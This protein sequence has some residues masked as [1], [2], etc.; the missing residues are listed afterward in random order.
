MTE[1][2]APKSRATWRDLFGR[3]SRAPVTVLA[4][5][6]LLFATNVYVTTSLLPNAV[7]DIGGK[8]LYS[9]TMTAFLVASVISSMLVGNTLA[10]FG[11]RTSYIGGFAG[12]SAGSVVAALAPSM[13][14]LLVG[15]AVQGLAAGLLAG[16][17]FAVIRVVLP[18]RLWQRSVALLSAMWG[19][20]NVAGPVIGGVFAEL[21]VWRAAF[22]FLALE[23]TVLAV[24]AW[25]TLPSHARTDAARQGVPGFALLLMAGGAAAVSIASTVHGMA[26][27]VLI[28]IGLLLVAGFVA[29]ERSAAVTV[30][31]AMTYRGRSPLRWVYAAIVVLAFVSTVETFLPL[32][33]QR[34]GGM[35][36]LGAGLL[37]ASLSWGWSL[38]SILNGGVTRPAVTRFV[39]AAGPALL[40]IGLLI[41]GVLQRQQPGPIVIA[42]WFVAL[43]IAGSG[44]GMAFA[45][46]VP[47][48]LRVSDDE[49][50]AS[51][52][53][54]GINTSQLIATAYGS[55][56]AG[57]LV[58]IGGPDV[59]SSAHLLTFGFAAIAV[60]GIPVANRALRSDRRWQGEAMVV[61][62]PQKVPSRA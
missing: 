35:A 60:L 47:A 17:A 39:R 52:A 19:V 53:S 26:T 55:A 54:A 12:F 9:W 18:P 4:G 33:G 49:Q 62:A 31:P 25:R 41:Y 3:E 11:A 23:A 57:V 45:H 40:A 27:G 36:P 59:L 58:S 6:V 7:A 22:G 29:R 24:L 44:I 38:G 50:V 30:L 51:K 48:A 13:Q 8:D 21:G 10:R 16:L 5:G 2:D 1:H 32:F 46:W 43:V 34:L 37:G 42:G 14:V 61:D 15:R 20:G 56:F 28:G